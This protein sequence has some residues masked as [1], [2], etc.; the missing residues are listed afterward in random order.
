MSR[1]EPLRDQ[2]VAAA[3]DVTAD[4]GW[5]AVTMARLA[6]QVGVSR[7]T[8]YNEVGTKPE[9]AEAMVMREL[10]RFLGG[11]EEAFDAAPD[12]LVAAVRGA[13]S[14]VLTLART[15]R[16]LQ[17][18]VS[19]QHGG[20]DELLPLLT[21]RSDG[22]VDT[23]KLVIARRLES[24]EVPLDERHLAA[25]IDMVVR[26]VLSHVMHPTGTPA[27]T[28]DDIAWIAGRTLAHPV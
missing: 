23:A 21:T 17:A 12:D 5:S 27:E 9:L 3:V 15:N 6:E 28:A 4:G 16:L 8:V 2:I 22:L 1:R 25:G 13:A 20:G 7:Q 26:L 19:A 11:V 24:Y 14:N 18:I 10:A